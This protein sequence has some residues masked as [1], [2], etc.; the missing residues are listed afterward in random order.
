VKSPQQTT[1][2]VNSAAWSPD[3]KTLASAGGEDKTLRLWDATTGKELSCLR[4]HT[5]TVTSA[6]WSPDGKTL[7]SAGGYDRML[8]L[9]D[10]A[11]P[12]KQP[13]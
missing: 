8:R 5:G 12:G 9:W 4:G 1:G 7:A 13:A 2:G 3:G 6:A 11:T 10:A